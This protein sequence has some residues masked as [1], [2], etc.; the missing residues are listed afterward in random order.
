MKAIQLT[1]EHKAKLLEMCKELF[2]EYNNDSPGGNGPITFHH[3]GLYPGMLFGFLKDNDSDLYDNCD[4]FIHWYEFCCKH[5]AAKI[6]NYNIGK[7]K[8]TYSS[9][10]G[11]CIITSCSNPIDYLYSEFKKL[12]T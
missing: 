4:L 10:V 7:T 5:L 6:Y 2:P 11:E 8:T 12:K 1:E 9:F 3:G